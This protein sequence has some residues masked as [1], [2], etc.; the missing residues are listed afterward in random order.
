ML[1]ILSLAAIMVLLAATGQ[2]F[3]HAMIL[4]ISALTTTGP[5]AS[6]APVEPISYE[7]LPDAAKWVLSGAMILGRLELLVLIALVN[8]AFWRA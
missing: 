5:L 2:G 3:E 6:F 8:P 4:S 1:F 7:F